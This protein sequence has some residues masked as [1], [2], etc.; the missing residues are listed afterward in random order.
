MQSQVAP[1][2]LIAMLTPTWTVPPTGAAK[3]T[4]ATC[5]TREKIISM[6]IAKTLTKLLRN[7]WGEVTEHINLSPKNSTP[8]KLL[9]RAA[10]G[11]REVYACMHDIHAALSCR[12]TNEINVIRAIEYEELTFDR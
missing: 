7:Y 11:S 3:I 4:Q 2:K 8:L 10:R 9:I 12:R 1:G 6:K 5:E